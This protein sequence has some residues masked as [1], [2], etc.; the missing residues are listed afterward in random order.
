M[1]DFKNLEGKK[2]LVTGGAGYVGA[3][4]VPMLLEKG[5]FVR[6]V[7]NLM[8]HQHTLFS[9]FINDNFEFVKGDV[10]DEATVR[11]AL[12][13]MDYIIHLAAIVGEPACKK[14]PKLCYEVNRDV[15]ALINRLRN[16][17]NQGLIFASTGSVYG[18]VDGICVEEC[19]LNPVSD[20]AIAKLES[21]RLIQKTKNYVIYRFAT[22]FGLSPRL[23]MDLIINDF[24]YRALKNRV[25]IV[26]EAN[27]KRTFVHVR[28]MARSFI[29]GIENFDN[30]KNEVYN[31]GSEALNFTK[32]DIANKIKEKID[33][34]LQFADFGT[35]PD[36]RNYEVSYAKI[37][38][39]GFETTIGLDRG[40]DELIRGYSALYIHNPF[41]NVD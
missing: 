18:K 24:T 32:A 19:A 27:F 10:R 34:H 31:I 30:L 25:N 28:D 7:D 40:I 37:R 41:S 21:E 14:D 5:Y 39:K 6:V 8:Y 12:D 13:G 16:P 15:T 3:V 22:A 36:Q 38:N 9:H 1:A 23:R 20:Y 2:V 17:E 29:F 26:Y 11:K 35:D 33:Y 4:L